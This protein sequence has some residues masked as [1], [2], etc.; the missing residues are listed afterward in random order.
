VKNDSYLVYG[1][2]STNNEQQMYNIT[3][4]ERE[5]TKRLSLPYQWGQ[6]QNNIDDQLTSFIYDIQLFDELLELLNNRFLNQVDLK[7]YALNRWYNFWSAIAVEQ[8]FCSQPNV[9]PCSNNKDK[10]ADFYLKG[11]RFDHKTTIFPYGFKQSWSY[12][13]NNPQELIKWLYL[14]QSQQGRKHLSNRLFIVLYDKN[15][16]HWKL[17]SN[18]TWLKTG[19]DNYVDNFDIKQLFGF[20]FLPN[21]VSWADVLFLEGEF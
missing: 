7:H 21:K 3:Q 9:K 10:K 17:K 6:K 19:V 13:H 15:G 16:A 4:I 20:T 11:I 8:I 5:L 2:L 14:H 12:A 18:I 1:V